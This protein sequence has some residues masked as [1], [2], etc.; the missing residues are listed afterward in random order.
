MR[1]VKSMLRAA[2]AEHGKSYCGVIGR[3]VDIIG[4][5]YLFSSSILKIYYKYKSCVSFTGN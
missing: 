4:G 2:Q 1:A 3:E 5:K